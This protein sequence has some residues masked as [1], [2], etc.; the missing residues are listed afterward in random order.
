[1][2]WA[3]KR[4]ISTSILVSLLFYSTL[5]PLT[6][7]VSNSNDLSVAQ[8]KIHHYHVD[9]VSITFALE[10]LS[11]N[12]QI[13]IG[14][15]LAPIDKDAANNSITVSKMNTTASEILD[16]IVRQSPGYEWA[17]IDGV[18][19]FF[20]T[21]NPDKFIEDILKVKFDNFKV[22]RETPRFQVRKNLLGHLAIER[23]AKELGVESLIFQYGCGFQ[24]CYI[25][26]D[27]SYSTALNNKTLKEILNHLILQSGMYFWKTYRYKNFYS[28]I[29]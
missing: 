14:A 11:N 19:N 26:G 16:E 10:K 29:F 20:H 17:E 6:S 15:I 18:I 3:S 25:G 22:E 7:H 2:T 21:N 12:F 9:R 5:L 13:P 4:F 23:K 8:I 24:S 28:I 27:S 1:M